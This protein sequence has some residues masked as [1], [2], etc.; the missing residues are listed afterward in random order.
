MPSPSMPVPVTAAEAADRM[1]R[2][3]GTVYS[4]VT[5]HGARRLKRVD[6][7]MYYDLNDLR[8]IEREIR[9]GHPVP[10][11][12]EARAEIA[13]ACPLWLQERQA[14]SEIAA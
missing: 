6:R 13:D 1:D 2:S 3:V 8:V 12:P 10:P 4:W 7:K 14:E 9:H 5:R 11:T